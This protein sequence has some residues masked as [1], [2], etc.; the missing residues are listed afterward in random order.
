MEIIL[1]WATWLFCKKLTG[2]AHRGV[3]KELEIRDFDKRTAISGP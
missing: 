2:I 1:L 3:L